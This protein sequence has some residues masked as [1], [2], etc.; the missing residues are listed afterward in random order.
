MAS[1]HKRL[2]IGALARM[3]GVNIETVRYYERIGLVPSPPRSEG[4]H[5]LFDDTHGR[6]LIFIRRDRELGFSLK[7]IRDLS[8]LTRGHGLTCGEVKALTEQ[9]VADIRAKI[10]DLR[11]LDRVLTDLSAKCHG[12]TVPDCPILDAL[13]SNEFSSAARSTLP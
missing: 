6:R 10:R 5:R 9:H 1:H 12:T 3:T 2:T 4:R 13:G 7:E 11:K 8:G